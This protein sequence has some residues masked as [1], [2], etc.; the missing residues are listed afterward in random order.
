M[1]NKNITIRMKPETIEQ[2]KNLQD[3]HMLNMSAL[4]RKAVEDKYNE[5]NKNG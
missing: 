2:V 4:F 1:K 3:E 5:L